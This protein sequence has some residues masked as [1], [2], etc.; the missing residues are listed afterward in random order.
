M[1]AE[2]AGQANMTDLSF[3]FDWLDGQRIGGGELSSTLASLRIDVMDQQSVTRVFDKRART[4]RD[5]I[6]VPLYPLAEWLVANW[7]FLKYEAETPVKK[8][9]VGFKHRHM[10]DTNGEGYA[11][12]NLNIVPSGERVRLS[13]RRQSP[14]WSKLDFL[15]DGQV[16]LDLEGFMGTCADFIDSVVRRLRAFDV[17]GTF[18]QNEWATIQNADDEEE[19]FCRVA[20]ELG[21]DPYNLSETKTEQIFQLDERL[22]HL[23][24]EAVP[25]LDAADPVKESS[26]ILAALAE[27]KDNS[28]QLQRLGPLMEQRGSQLTGRPWEIGYRL[29]QEARRHLN[30]DGQPIATFASLA[31]VL[32]EDLK[33]IEQATRPSVALNDVQL[34]DGVVTSGEQRRVAFA[35][36]RTNRLDNRRFLF[37]RALAEA[38]V[39]D[40]DAVITKG[41]TEKQQCNRAFAAE[42]LAP[43]S[44]LRARIKSLVIDEGEL[45]DLAEDFGVSTRVIEHQ[46]SNHR[47]ARLEEGSSFWQP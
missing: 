43:S 18:L 32:D 31:Q 35:L 38:L 22:G 39:A 28:L 24:D 29:A 1:A 30:L 27:A 23:R 33:S 12:P 26:A 7:W 5:S 40:A 8:R 20:A 45:V 13:W 25:V 47:L 34:V 15:N 11:W 21:W 4:V 10:L 6:D 36:A 19:E 2:H 37:C 9:A 14:E 3:E 42:F 17:E 44:G 16:S 41:D 46:I